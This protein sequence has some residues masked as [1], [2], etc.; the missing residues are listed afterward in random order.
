MVEHIYS[1]IMRR[2]Q[3]V[4]FTVSESVNK[5]RL[6]RCGV[7][8]GSNLRIRGKI[9]IQNFG[10]IKIGKHVTI[11]SC[12]GAN[13]ISASNRTSFQVAKGAILKIGNYSGISNSFITCQQKIIIEDHVLIGA[14]CQIFDTDFHPTESRYRYGKEK[15]DEFI[16]KRETRIETGVFIGTNCIILKGAHIGKNSIIGAGS[17][18]RGNIPSGEIWAGNP[19]VKIGNAY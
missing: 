19:A 5:M 11:N 6:K 13:P 7:S 18:V 14:G 4:S 10:T 15:S 2:I 16:K 3:G 17:V 1:K 8:Y 9:Y 12:F